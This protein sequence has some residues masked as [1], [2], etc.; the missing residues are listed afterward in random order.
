MIVLL[1]VNTCFLFNFDIFDI[2][3]S[4]RKPSNRWPWQPYQIQTGRN[5]ITCTKARRYDAKL[6]YR[7]YRAAYGRYTYQFIYGFNFGLFID[8]MEY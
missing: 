7:S 8:M 1:C 2:L 4:N 3:Y 6:I 5:Q